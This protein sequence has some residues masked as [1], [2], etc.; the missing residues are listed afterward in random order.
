MSGGGQVSGVDSALCRQ[1][2]GTDLAAGP[3]RQFPGYES[4]IATAAMAGAEL[5]TARLNHQGV[6]DAL[7]PV[8]GFP[9]RQGFD[10]PVVRSLAA[11]GSRL[12]FANGAP[13][14]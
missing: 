10:E 14:D 3:A 1:T 2:Q 5:A 6:L 11:S 13:I 9:D 12:P 8:L 4:S 7:Q